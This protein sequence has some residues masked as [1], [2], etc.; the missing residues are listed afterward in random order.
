MDSAIVPINNH[1]ELSLVQSV[2]FFYPLVDDPYTMGRIALANVVSDVYAVGVVSID[3]I[4]MILSSCTEFTDQEREVVVPMII[5][6]FRDAAR[7]AGCNVK[8]QNIAE[9]PWC[10][11]GGVASSI[12]LNN[13]IIP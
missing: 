1:P 3:K 8:I 10:I 11:I 9:N 7:D 6:G 2:D 4:G 13:E 5:R 12:C